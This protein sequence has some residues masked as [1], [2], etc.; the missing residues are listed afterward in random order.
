MNFR[1]SLR[2]SRAQ[3]IITAID[4]GNEAGILELYTATKPAT[5]AAITTQT[6]LGTL[7]FSDPCGTVTDGVLTFGAWTPDAS[8]DNDG[9]CT[10]GRISSRNSGVST[11]VM[12][13]SITE[14]GG[15]GDFII[16]TAAVVAGG[17]ISLS[18]T[19]TITEG[20]A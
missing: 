8:A 17:S 10:W 4:E 12:D 14:A 18:G 19:A 6:K 15:G 16:N 3:D 2:T 20:N 1:T 9:T 11:F 7:T 5:G 13:V